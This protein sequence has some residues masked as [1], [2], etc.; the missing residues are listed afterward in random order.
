MK[1]LA[2]LAVP[3]LLVAAALTLS[4]RS[5]AA[6]RAT[7]L[8]GTVGP[9]F[10]ITLRTARGKVVK[11]LRPGTYRIRVR[12]LS[13]IH[14]FHLSGPGVNKLTRGA[15]HGQRDLDRAAQARCLPLPL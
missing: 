6:A 2:A 14:N 12:D 9:G 8:H 10:T 3:L 4:G 1:R 11:K 7:V 5:Q 15:E 13:P